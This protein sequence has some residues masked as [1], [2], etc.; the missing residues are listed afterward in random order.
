MQ[1]MFSSVSLYCIFFKSLEDTFPI[2]IHCS[3]KLFIG[4]PH[5]Y[6]FKVLLKKLV[7]VIIISL[8]DM[9]YYDMIYDMNILFITCGCYEDE[10]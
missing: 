10:C 2:V 6:L 4:A 8:L 5:G 1:S 7:S 9:Y 3:S